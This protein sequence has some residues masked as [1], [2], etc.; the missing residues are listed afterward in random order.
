VRLELGFVPGTDTQR[1]VG[2]SLNWIMEPIV[3][4]GDR[5]DD[6]DGDRDGWEDA[7]S[8]TTGLISLIVPPAPSLYMTVVV[9]A[10]A[11]SKTAMVTPVATEIRPPAAVTIVPAPPATDVPADAAA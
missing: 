3:R 1:P 10:A 11:T 7:M 8:S 6:R 5:D 2:G 4:T 9:A